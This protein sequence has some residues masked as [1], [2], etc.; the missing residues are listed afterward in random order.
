MADQR[1][2]IV[3]TIKVKPESR[4]QNLLTAFKNLVEETKKEE[5]NISYI[6]HNDVKD[7]N[8]FVFVEEWRSSADIEKHM[9][10]PHFTGF[11]GKLKAHLV[12][13]PQIVT[14]RPLL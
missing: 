5:G 12:S 4:D 3:A 8:T 10:S 13:A 6:L 9:K 1:L 14:I 2:R 7:P 11:V